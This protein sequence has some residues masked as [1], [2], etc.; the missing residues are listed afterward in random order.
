MPDNRSRRIALSEN[1]VLELF[2]REMTIGFGRS[3]LH[4]GK[5][6]ETEDSGL[7]NALSKA[8]R[9]CIR[10]RWVLI[11][12][13]A[14]F[15]CGW[16]ASLIVLVID[17]IENDPLSFVP[18]T[19]LLCYGSLVL[20]VFMVM[21]QVFSDVIRDGKPFSLPQA[22]RLGFISLVALVFV[23]VELL[24][25]AGLSYD[26]IP[27]YGYSMVINDGNS[28]PTIKLTFG[29]ISICCAAPATQRR[30]R[31]R[32]LLCLLFLVSTE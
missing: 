4:G 24:F 30:N 22:D 27:E 1:R 17:C 11:C 32:E 14:L 2:E 31:V 12:V 13:T 18:L 20:A 10:V 28:E 23:I 21:L 9:A 26:L 6:D 25:T 15:A 19:Y 8:K 7:V 16:G 5:M 29:N 3:S